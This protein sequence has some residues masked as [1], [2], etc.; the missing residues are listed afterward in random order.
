MQLCYV[1]PSQPA[2][3]PADVLG[4]TGCASGPKWGTDTLGDPSMC[5]GVPQFASCFQS[6]QVH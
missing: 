5:R 6:S 3:Q 2:S 4:I 1:V